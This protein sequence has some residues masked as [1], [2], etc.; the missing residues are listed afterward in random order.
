M[1]RA[2][3]TLAGREVDDVPGGVP[4]EGGRRSVPRGGLSSSR[5]TVGTARRSQETRSWPPCDQGA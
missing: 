5:R 4:E 2:V 1:F 3:F